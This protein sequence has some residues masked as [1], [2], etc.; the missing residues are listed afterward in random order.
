MIA[1]HDPDDLGDAAVNKNN[2]DLEGPTF[3]SRIVTHRRV[4]RRYS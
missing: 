1:C 3:I 2:L 4:D